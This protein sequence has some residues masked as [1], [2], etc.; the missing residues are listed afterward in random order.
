[1]VFRLLNFLSPDTVNLPAKLFWLF[2]EPVGKL[3]FCK[4]TNI[5]TGWNTVLAS[6]RGLPYLLF[7]VKGR[8]GESGLCLG[9]SHFLTNFF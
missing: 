6:V 7:E 3:S 2:T 9:H 1:M 4:C 8:G 5:P